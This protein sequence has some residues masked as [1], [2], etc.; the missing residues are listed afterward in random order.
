M[1]ALGRHNLDV[2]QP[3]H[4]GGGPR[5]CRPCAVAKAK[6]IPSEVDRSKCERGV[7]YRC[8][9]LKKEC[10]GQERKARRKRK[11][12]PRQTRVAQLERK[13]DD[14]VNLLKSSHDAPAEDQESSKPSNSA[15][16]APSPVS[17]T[18]TPSATLCI[19]PL[20]EEGLA[21]EAAAPMPPTRD[22]LLEHSATSDQNTFSKSDKDTY[23]TIFKTSMARYFPFV[24]IDDHISA[25]ELGRT[26]PFLLDVILVAAFHRDSGR[27]SRQL[28]NLL[29]LAIA[30]VA[31]L[32][33]NRP[34]PINKY[35]AVP[36]VMRKVLQGSKVFETLRGTLEERRTF[37]GCFYLSSLF[38][39]HLRGLEPL[40]YT[41]YV[42]ECCQALVDA[43]QYPDDNYLVQLVR[44]QRVVNIIR[45]HVL[46][47]QYKLRAPFGMHIAS[48][49]SELNSVK[50]SW[51]DVRNRNLLL[52]HYHSAEMFLHEFAIYDTPSR[53]GVLSDN[54][55]F[56]RVESLYACL[57][58]AA[59][60]VEAFFTI[61]P[62]EYIHLSMTPWLQVGHMMIIIR[63]LLFLDVPGWDL[64]YVRSKL[65][66]PG[67]LDRII[68]NASEARQA[69][70]KSG[71]GQDG[72][73]VHYRHDLLAE[74]SKKMGALKQ[75]F[76]EAIRAEEQMQ[77]RQLSQ[78]AQPSI[79]GEMWTGETLLSMDEDFWEGFWQEWQALI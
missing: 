36:D 24:V 5:A 66:V 44:I 12:A 43:K 37:L 45:Q 65:D 74:L 4:R 33:L 75:N 20:Q 64:K 14:I 69:A 30:L 53:S 57:E 29:Q 35:K 8:S 71:I 26:K 78:P 13:L 21:E 70:K 3:G 2:V 25:E 58:A 56:Q 41:P 62:E 76:N 54:D 6:C 1:D 68:K 46:D 31:D 23:L 79:L 32:G 52:M 15:Y 7:W 55:P 47:D 50:Q 9:R 49:Q 22:P 11:T 60:L 40:P 77:H 59:A 19:R 63:K 72:N 27:Q 61:Q 10:V 48:I 67:M 17:M 39:S 73:Y 34:L 28:T 38:S 18:Q 42:E 51:G 16:P